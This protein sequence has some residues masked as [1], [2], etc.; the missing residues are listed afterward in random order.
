TI[1]VIDDTDALVTLFHD[2]LTGHGQTVLKAYSGS[3][4]IDLYRQHHVDLVLCD[5]GMPGMSGWDVGW[6]V[7]SICRDKGIPKT[8]FVLLTGWAGQSLDREL[9]EQ[10]GIDGVLEK[11][12]DVP[13]LFEMIRRVVRDKN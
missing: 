9:I 13:R 8:P 2:L 3:Q 4:G 12:V 1:L 7:R 6:M 5:L 10:S 11:P